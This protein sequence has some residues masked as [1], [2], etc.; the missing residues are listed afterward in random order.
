MTLGSMSMEK[1]LKNSVTWLLTDKTSI[2]F[3]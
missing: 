1:Q 2:P 3:N